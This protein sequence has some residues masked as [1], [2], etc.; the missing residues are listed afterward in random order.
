V[1]GIPVTT[2]GLPMTDDFD[3]AIY[4]KGDKKPVALYDAQL[5][6][7]WDDTPIPIP[8]DV[9][10]VVGELLASATTILDEVGL[11]IAVKGTACSDMY[12]V[13]DTVIT[14]DPLA[15]TTV[16]VGDTVNVTTSG[17]PCTGEIVPVPDI[18]VCPTVLAATATITDADL[19]VNPVNTNEASVVC[20]AGT[21]IRTTPSAGTEVAIGS[22]VTLVVST[23][24][25]D[26][27]DV[28]IDTFRVPTAIEPRS[29]GSLIVRIVNAADAEASG[30]VIVTLSG[31]D[32]SLFTASYPS[33]APG[34]AER[35]I[36][37]WMA[38][39]E[40]QTVEWSLNVTVSGEIVDTAT[41]ETRVR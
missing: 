36:F 38:P 17:G 23:G 18:G 7:Q 14:Q 27:S 24:T 10:A 21:V 13:I 35:V 5:K 2:N 32:G 28:T 30:P 16:A 6:L 20:A 8:V 26:L 4:I 25:A 40:S 34:G 12:P 19:T 29:Q 15:G 9:P 1:N 39:A 11:G 3:L 37:R 41:A 31:S 22:E 33:L